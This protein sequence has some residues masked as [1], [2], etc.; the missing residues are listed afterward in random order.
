MGFDLCLD[1]RQICKFHLPSLTFCE[2][3]SGGGTARGT[4]S[5]P[6]EAEVSQSAVKRGSAA[7]WFGSA[8]GYAWSQ[9]KK[10]L[11]MPQDLKE[12]RA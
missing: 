8:Q 7:P 9:E 11:V 10:S 6:H 4:F 2:C 1:S 3:R 5:Q 12:V